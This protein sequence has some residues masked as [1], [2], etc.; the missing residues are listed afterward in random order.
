MSSQEQKMWFSDH[1]HYRAASDLKTETEEMQMA[2]LH[3]CLE[4]E[5]R[6]WAK[7][8]NVKDQEEAIK[9]LKKRCFEVINPEINRQIQV[10]RMSQAKT[11]SASTLTVRLRTAYRQAEINQADWDRIE[12]LLILKSITYDSILKELHKDIYRV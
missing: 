1:D 9:A 10:F 12:C 5:I 8:D 2:Y 11:E 4:P 7:I 6:A 3:L